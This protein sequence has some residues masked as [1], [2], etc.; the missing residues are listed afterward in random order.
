M[1]RRRELIGLAGWAAL[2]FATAAVGAVASAR[3][4]SFYGQLERPPWAPP[5]WLFSP[6]WTALYILMAIAAWPVW[7]V[8]AAFGA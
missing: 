5:S 1:P 8:A 2:T 3:A 6:V 7:L 4:A